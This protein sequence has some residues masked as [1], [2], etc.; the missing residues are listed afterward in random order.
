[1]LAQGIPLMLAGDEVNNS[2][3]GN[4]NTY[5]QDNEIGWIDWSALGG[6]DDLTDFVGELT[7]LRQRFPQISQDRWLEG[8]KEDGTYGVKWLTPAGQEMSDEDWNFPDGR[9]VSYVLAAR[10]EGGAPLFIVLNGAETDLE[11]TFPEWPGAPHWRKCSI[12]RWAN[13]R[14]SS[15][16]PA[17]HGRC[18]Q[19]SV[20]AFAGEP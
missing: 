6:E 10:R 3:N 14:R 13:R 8:R 18:A 15:A 16:T 20:L 1:M 17:R 7:R 2:Q 11:I 4:N 19:R 12:P 5:C 9:F